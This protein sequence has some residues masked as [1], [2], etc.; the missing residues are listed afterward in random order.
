MRLSPQ[1]SGQCSAG[2]AEVRR[3][4]T[5]AGNGGRERKQGTEAGPDE[6]DRFLVETRKQKVETGN[7]KL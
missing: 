4:G 5:E 7:Q 2:K 3:Q 6:E 1:W